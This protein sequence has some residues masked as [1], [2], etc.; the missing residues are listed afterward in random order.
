MSADEGGGVP[1]KITKENGDFGCLTRVGGY[2]KKSDLFNFDPLSDLVRFGQTWSDGHGWFCDTFWGLLVPH[3]DFL[4][5][6][7]SKSA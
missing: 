3:Q 6:K 1:P 4:R 7:S 2:P 5:C